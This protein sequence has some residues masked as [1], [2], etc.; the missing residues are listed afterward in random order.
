[1]TS[2]LSVEKAEE[3]EAMLTVQLPWFSELVNIT[4]QEILKDFYRQKSLEGD[5]FSIFH[6][7]LNYSFP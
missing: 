7:V 5:Q 4:T 1:M 2:F 3:G 6:S